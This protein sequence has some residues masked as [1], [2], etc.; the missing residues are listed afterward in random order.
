[1]CGCD[2]TIDV[3]EVIGARALSVSECERMDMSISDGTH[4]KVEIGHACKSIESIMHSCR[5]ERL[6]GHL[7]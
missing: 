3:G 1:M 6:V 4:N 2:I 7:Q 5:N